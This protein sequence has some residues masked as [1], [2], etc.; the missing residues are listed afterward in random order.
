VRRVR[1]RRISQMGENPIRKVLAKRYGSESLG[2]SWR[3]L[4]LSVGQQT[5]G[6]NENGLIELR[7]HTQVPTNSNDGK[8]QASL[9]ICEP[10][11]F[12][13]LFLFLLRLFGRRR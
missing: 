6:R 1:K 9:A 8:A 12:V 13:N 4:W 3:Q 2:Q 11:D 10:D 7:K 5:A